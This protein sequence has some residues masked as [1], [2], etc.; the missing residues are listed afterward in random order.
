METFDFFNLK[1]SKKIPVSVAA[2]LRLRVSLLHRVH[3]RSSLIRVSVFIVCLDCQFAWIVNARQKP[4]EVLGALPNGNG[5]RRVQWN[6]THV[7][8]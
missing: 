4:N 1:K 2:Q 8:R 7:Y 5:H 3:Q 6:G